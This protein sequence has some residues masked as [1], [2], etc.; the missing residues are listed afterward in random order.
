MAL[1]LYDDLL[2]SLRVF[3]DPPTTQSGTGF[4]EP[5]N[6][7]DK[8]MQLPL[9][10]AQTYRGLHHVLPLEAG[11]LCWLVVSTQ[12]VTCTQDTFAF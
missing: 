10:A 7:S 4:Y 12:A 3:G 2:R 6:I 11:Y 9:I 1:A 5:S 8:R